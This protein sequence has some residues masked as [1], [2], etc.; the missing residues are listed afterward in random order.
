LLVQVVRAPAS[1]QG[2]RVRQVTRTK[3]LVPIASITRPTKRPVM[4]DRPQTHRQHRPGIKLKATPLG[5]LRRKQAQY[6]RP[7]ATFHGLAPLCRVVSTQRTQVWKVAAFM[8]RPIA[9]RWCNLFFSLREGFAQAKACGYES[10]R[11]ENE[12]IRRPVSVHA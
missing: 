9:P 7:Q 11:I 3:A 6:N 2:A 4:H 12:K 10:C 5:G 1:G 8:P